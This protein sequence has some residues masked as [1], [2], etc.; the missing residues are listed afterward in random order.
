GKA[1][2]FEFLIENGQ[3]Y[4]NVISSYPTMS[5]TI[6]SSLLTGAFADEHHIP[7]LI[8]FNEQAKRIVSYGSG[9][10]EIWNT[11]VRNVVQD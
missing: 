9:P 8:W 5:V 4:P 7:G 3:F 10:T 1:P 6:D 2:A 11:G